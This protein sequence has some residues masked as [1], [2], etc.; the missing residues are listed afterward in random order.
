MSQEV[1]GKIGGGSDEKGEGQLGA[2]E[3][4]GV[5][6]AGCGMRVNSEERMLVLTD[7]QQE[8]H[9]GGQ[10]QVLMPRFVCVPGFPG[11]RTS[12]SSDPR[13]LGPN[14]SRMGGWAGQVLGRATEVSTNKAAPTPRRRCPTGL[15]GKHRTETAN[16]QLFFVTPSSV[17]RGQI[18]WE[19]MWPG[20][21]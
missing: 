12:D 13:L 7:S 6:A 14:W 4:R 10:I 9:Q 21:R 3:M 15:Y 18:F 11:P 16:Y 19:L 5:L 17:R 8:G 2:N 20:I 1:T